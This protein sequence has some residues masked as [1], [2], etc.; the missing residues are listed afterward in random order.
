[1]KSTSSTSSAERGRQM[2]R[3][4]SGVPKH[5]LPCMRGARGVAVGRCERCVQRA[6]CSVQH[7]QLKKLDLEDRTLKTSGRQH[8]RL[9]ELRSNSP[10]TCQQPS[11]QRMW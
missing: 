3:S 1:M 5:Q 6:V 4:V 9:K 2:P 8:D 11:K 7:A 10:G